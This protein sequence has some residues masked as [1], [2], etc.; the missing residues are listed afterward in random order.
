MEIFTPFK[1]SLC[2]NLLNLKLWNRSVEY[3]GTFKLDGNAYLSVY[4]CITNPLMEC[5]I[6]DSYGTHN[7][8]DAPEATQKGNVTTDGDTYQIWTKIRINKLLI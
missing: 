6:V 4:G 5:Y 8:S 1:M 2:K 7:P 3:S